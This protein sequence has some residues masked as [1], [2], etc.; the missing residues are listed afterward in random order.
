V[1]FDDKLLH[2]L[3]DGAGGAL[4]FP[5]AAAS[6]LLNGTEDVSGEWTLRRTVE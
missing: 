3:C 5:V 1:H 4:H 2:L 6:S